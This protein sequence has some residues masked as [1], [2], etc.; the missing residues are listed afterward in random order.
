MVGSPSIG[1]GPTE[2]DA[3]L[4]TGLTSV[5]SPWPTCNPRARRPAGTDRRMS[6]VD[7]SAPDM[8]TT[9]R[10]VV[11]SDAP[12]SRFALA[13]IAPR[14]STTLIDRPLVVGHSADCDVPLVGDDAAS[15]AHV[16][17]APSAHGVEITDLQSRNGTFLDGRRI[18]T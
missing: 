10:T 14:V 1:G 18:T 7:M 15:R 11:A 5:R 17:V 8:S 13:I 12:I 9:R 6:A 3:R 4:M 2:S 16:R